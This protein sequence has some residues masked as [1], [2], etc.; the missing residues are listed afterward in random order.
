[1]VGSVGLCVVLA[2]VVASVVGPVYGAV[3]VVIDPVTIP[4]S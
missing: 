3:V 4:F 1:V 2:R